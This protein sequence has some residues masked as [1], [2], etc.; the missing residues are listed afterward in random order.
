M[1]DI[2]TRQVDRG[3]NAMADDAAELQYG[4]AADGSR[5][6]LYPRGTI[7]T[8][9]GFSK[10]AS[11]SLPLSGAILDL[12]RWKELDMTEHF[13]AVTPEKI[14]NKNNQ[15][16][17][18]DDVS[19]SGND[20]NANIY[21]PV[22]H[23]VIL[24]T[25]G[26]ALNGTGDN[27]YK[28]CL[29]CPGTVAPIQ[30]WAGKNETDFADLL[31]ADDY[32]H[33]SSSITKHYA[34]QVGSLAS[35]VLLISAKEA[36]AVDSLHDCNQRIRWSQA[37]KLE[38]YTGTG[39]G[40]TDLFETG[41]ENIFGG[42]LGNQWIQ[43]QNNSTWSLNWVGG[44][45]VFRPRIEFPDIGLLGP[46]LLCI[47]NN[48]HY[49]VGSDFNVYAYK[50]GSNIRPIG[51][52]IQ[53]YLERDLSPAYAYR[54]WMTVGAKGSRIWIYIVP[55]GSE[56]VTQAYAIDTRTGSWMKRDFTH[57][58]AT[59][60]AGISAA[61]LIGA[62]SYMIGD[63]YADKLI[64]RSPPK[65]V[66][67]GGCV[68]SSNVVTVTTD[69]AHSFIA[70]ETAV[71]AS[72]DSGGE[73]DA[74]SGS[75]TIASVPSTTTFTFSQNGADES[76]LA[77]GTALVD[78]APTS[79]DYITYATT[80]RMA[81]TEI[82]TDERIVIG[83][84]AGYIYQYDSDLIQDDG[85]DIPSRHITEV[86][87]TGFPGRN[88][89]WPGI[90]ITAK[91]TSVVISYRT[92]N[93]E[94]IDTGWTDFDATSLT[95]EFADYFIPINDTS[96]K[97]QFKFSSTGDDFQISSYMINAPILLGRV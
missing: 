15:D 27:W 74:F 92:G 36:D 64:E 8:P 7:K 37:G 22:S 9:Y 14:Y 38:S 26:I 11:S 41:G 97:I 24:H 80:S 20:L 47:K 59:T 21:N 63:T 34:L 29:V 39:S 88:K 73:T 61:G 23:S 94:T 71:L 58:W 93:F 57:K 16:D 72:V 75:H 40:Y 32:H 10:I 4:G 43:Y 25:D 49:F 78:K 42:L 17:T 52:N 87:D 91:G 68:R 55:D 65:N 35:R 79:Q 5:N 30:R 31:G 28:H 54:C 69:V 85:I 86:C 84:S 56:F 45:T 44:T 77:A 2:V 90:T 18:W 33:T 13:M 89:L 76:N 1:Q 62:G 96:K 19:Q 83:D 53:K 82:L 50:G 66:A 6:V 67:I 12:F 81:M 70:G 60:S 46:H 95:S 51:D 3:F 48:V